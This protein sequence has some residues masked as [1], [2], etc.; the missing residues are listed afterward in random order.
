MGI[1]FEEVE[2]KC[3][4]RSQRGPLL[5]THW[6]LSG[7]AVLKMSAKAAIDLHQL[8]YQFDI[9]VNFL[10]GRKE[11]ALKLV[12]ETIRQNKGSTRI[13]AER[14]F[15]LPK[16]FWER[17]CESCGIGE[18]R[19]WSELNN[20]TIN[21]LMENLLNYRFKV[22]GKST[23]KEEFVTAG[24]VDL[25]E[26]DF[27]TFECKRFPGLFMAGEVLNIDAETGGFNFQAAWTA[28]RI[29]AESLGGDAR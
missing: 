4:K 14:M 9:N 20:K 2:L 24:G 17:I 11:E 18:D 6:G 13:K 5:I 29:I 16:R 3:G 1:S 19:K 12:L 8:N 27:K 28:A 10:P 22:E 25:R 26:I 7:P 23:F 15:E 21:K